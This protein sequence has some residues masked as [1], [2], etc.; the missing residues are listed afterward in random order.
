MA[1]AAPRGKVYLPNPKRSSANALGNMQTLDRWRAGLEKPISRLVMGT[2]HL[3][4][5]PY[6]SVMLDDFFEQGAG[7]VKS[8]WHAQ[9]M[10]HV[11]ATG[12]GSRPKA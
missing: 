12:K 1:P 5:W 9:G 6:A 11:F 7:L 4:S 3:T 2:M 8:R 10:V